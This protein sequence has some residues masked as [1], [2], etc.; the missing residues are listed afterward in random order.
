MGNYLKSHLVVNPPDPPVL[1]AMNPVHNCC[2][3]VLF[4]DYLL[5][6]SSIIILH[7]FKCCFLLLCVVCAKM[8]KC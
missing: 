8:H 7:C 1:Q 2:P 6:S 4:S 3:I 5:I